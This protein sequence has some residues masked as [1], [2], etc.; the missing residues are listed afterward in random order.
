MLTEGT[1]DL[2]RYGC[3]WL[4]WHHFD[5]NLGAWFSFRFILRLFA[6]SVDGTF[7]RLFYLIRLACYLKA[8]WVDF[9][10]HYGSRSLLL[11]IISFFDLLSHNIFYA[12]VASW[13]T[14]AGCDHRLL[15]VVGHDKARDQLKV[16]SV[17][18]LADFA[19]PIRLS[20]LWL[21]RLPKRAHKLGHNLAHA[22]KEE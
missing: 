4:N 12:C 9:L 5:I 18:S 17:S 1:A 3:S 13:D 11:L 8:L 10:H 21:I 16:L 7:F 20:K 14:A 22:K 6:I 2:H 19:C 15:D